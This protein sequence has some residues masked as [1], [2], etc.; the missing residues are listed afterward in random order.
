MHAPLSDD[1]QQFRHLGSLVCEDLPNKSVDTL[2]RSGPEATTEQ[3]RAVRQCRKVH[4]SWRLVKAGRP[5]FP[6]PAELLPVAPVAGP[7]LAL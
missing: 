4:L 2:V 5:K 1:R 7:A 6:I 3:L